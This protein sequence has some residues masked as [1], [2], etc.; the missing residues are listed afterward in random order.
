M[1]DPQSS[2]KDV[3]WEDLFRM[4]DELDAMPTD[5]ELDAIWA[6]KNGMCRI[7]KVRPAHPNLDGVCGSCKP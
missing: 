2:P 5:E 7:C 1:S 4:V 6:E 3:S